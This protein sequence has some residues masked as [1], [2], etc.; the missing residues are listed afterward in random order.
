MVSVAPG[1]TS[2]QRDVAVPWANV[3]RSQGE[4]RNRQTRRL[5]VPVSER[6]WG[7][8]SPLAHQGKG[9]AAGRRY[10]FTDVVARVHGQTDGAVRPTTDQFYVS[11]RVLLERHSRCR[12]V[13]VSLRSRRDVAVYL[14]GEWFGGPTPQPSP[15]VR[16]VHYRANRDDVAATAVATSAPTHEARSPRGLK[17]DQPPSR[18]RRPEPCRAVIFCSYDP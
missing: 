17:R 14:V 9:P 4:W 7:F 6:M 15:M 5:Q 11:E 10:P 1:K 18:V 13:P 3:T 16:E 12:V 8:K 2:A